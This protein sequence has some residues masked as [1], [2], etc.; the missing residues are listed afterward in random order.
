MALSS[1]KATGGVDVQGF[2]Q[3]HDAIPCQ[4]LT[5][6][7]IHRAKSQTTL[8]LGDRSG[9][10]GDHRWHSTVGAP[11]LQDRSP[12][13]RRTPVA[14]EPRERGPMTPRVPGSRLTRK[15]PLLGRQGPEPVSLRR[16]LDRAPVMTSGGAPV[17][18]VVRAERTVVPLFWVDSRQPACPARGFGGVWNEDPDYR[19]RGFHWQPCH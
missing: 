13:R 3:S 18:W 2:R 10:R 12:S 6:G 15:E 7:G 16:C 4:R 9:G 11:R 17:C 1:E 19:W 14:P 5:P 8:R